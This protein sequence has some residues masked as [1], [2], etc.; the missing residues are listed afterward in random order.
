[1]KTKE[2]VIR[3]SINRIEKRLKILQDLFESTPISRIY[4]IRTEI[5]NILSK[6]L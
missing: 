6:T 1:M 5:Y 3:K 2:K 4:E